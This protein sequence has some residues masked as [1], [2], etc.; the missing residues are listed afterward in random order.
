[1]LSLVGVLNKREAM[2]PKPSMGW[3]LD[4]RLGGATGL[5]HYSTTCQK[6]SL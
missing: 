6:H 3:T 4:T 5:D 1:M 2:A